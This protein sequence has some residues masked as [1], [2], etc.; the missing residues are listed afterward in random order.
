MF[1]VDANT[2]QDA[3]TNT[4]TFANHSSITNNVPDQT[5]T[6]TTTTHKT[7]SNTPNNALLAYVQ[8]TKTTTVPQSV[9]TV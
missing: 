9:H 7:P 5:A 4:L 2:A 3:D 1:L 6:N 8:T